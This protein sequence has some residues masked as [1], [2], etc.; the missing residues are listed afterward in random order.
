MGMGLVSGLF[1]ANCLAGSLLGLAQ[2]LSWWYMHLS[3]K[4]DSSAKDSGR[5]VVSS[6]PLAPPKISLLVFREALCSLLGPPVVRQLMQ[7]AILMPGQHGQFQP[8][9]P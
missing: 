2:G 4:M 7:V 1:L 9:V 6:H 8:K 3:D 5:L